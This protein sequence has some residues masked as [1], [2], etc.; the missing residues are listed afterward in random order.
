MTRNRKQSSSQNAR[1]RRRGFTMIELAITVS[2]IALL[3]GI[4]L[5]VLASVRNKAR[6]AEVKKEIGDLSSAL[7]LFKDKYGTY[8]PSRI[9][10]Y[11]NTTSANWQTNDPYGYAAIRKLWPK[12]NFNTAG[13]FPFSPLR[14]L[15]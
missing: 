13:G 12:F 8:P 10:L 9:T 14:R 4:L 6:V 11:N 7:E 3:V 5:P 1:N 15:R 2:I